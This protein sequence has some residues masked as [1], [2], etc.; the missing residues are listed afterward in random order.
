M[1]KYTQYCDYPPDPIQPISVPSHSSP[2]I[3]RLGNSSHLTSD[4]IKENPLSEEK[5]FI[6]SRH[7]WLFHIMLQ[8]LNSSES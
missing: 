4:V 6:N 1:N 3:Y 2:G 8:H 5:I 7:I